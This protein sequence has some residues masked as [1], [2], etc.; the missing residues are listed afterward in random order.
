V[1]V[2]LAAGI[3]IC[4]AQGHRVVAVVTGATQG[5]I[6]GSSTFSEALDS[7][8]VLEYH[9]LML[10]PEGSPPEHKEA[11]F[12]KAVDRATVNFWQAYDTNEALTVRFEHWWNCVGTWLLVHQVELDGAKIWAIE[13]AWTS[14]G[15]IITERIRLRYVQLT[16]TNWKP[17]TDCTGT[18]PGQNITVNGN[19]SPP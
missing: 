19:L 6:Q 13:P 1:A 5:T 2:V 17:R 8:D 10:R 7:I 3:L 9:H 12:T 18:E 11:I 16:L 4:S 14:A 15:G